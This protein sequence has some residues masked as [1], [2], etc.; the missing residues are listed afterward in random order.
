MKTFIAPVLQRFFLN[1]W[2]IT[3]MAIAIIIATPVIFVFS[4][5][6]TD[7]EAIWQHLLD[8]VLIDYITNSLWLMG[9]VGIGV[10]S[11][12]VGTAWLVT[13][14]RFGGSGWLE[15]LLLLPLAAPAYLLAYAYTNLLDYFGPV[16]TALRSIFGW[17]SIQ[18]YWFPSIRSLWGAMAMLILV[19]YPYVY[20]LAR[21]AFLEQS[22]CTLEATRSLGC[23]PWRSFFYY[24]PTFS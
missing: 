8:T 7:A 2:I 12:G 9:G 13:M 21:V 22:A 14:C 16:Q 20:L 23:N 4:S 1:G 24:C 6:F 3:V 15:W 18:D 5:I 10:L 17:T 19:L 11:I